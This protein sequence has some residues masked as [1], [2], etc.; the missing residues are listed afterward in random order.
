MCTAAVTSDT[1]GKSAPEELW[2]FLTKSRQIGFVP[3]PLTL[4]HCS[5]FRLSLSLAGHN[6][7]ISI[8]IELSVSH[9]RTGEE[10]EE[11]ELTEGEHEIEP[12]DRGW[13]PPPPIGK[14]LGKSPGCEKISLRG[15]KLDRAESF[16]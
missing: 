13:L 5:A 16:K 10:G 1:F 8:E 3:L 9:V 4:P 7:I 15:S 14:I 11:E 6:E 12:A 2:D